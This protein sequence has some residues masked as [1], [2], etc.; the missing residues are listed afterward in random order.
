MHYRLPDATSAY[1]P[2][3]QNYASL[4]FE[5]KWVFGLLWTVMEMFRNHI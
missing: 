1:G 4:F 2:F 3:E 5:L